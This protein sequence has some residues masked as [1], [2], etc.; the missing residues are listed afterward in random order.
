MIFSFS[1]M[2][3][4]TTKMLGNLIQRLQLS[5]PTLNTS[6]VLPLLDHHNYLIMEVTAIWHIDRREN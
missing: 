5:L 1:L 6:S 4:I 3:V 2:I